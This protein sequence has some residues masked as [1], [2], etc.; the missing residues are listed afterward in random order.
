[1][2]TRKIDKF[3][4]MGSHPLE[5]HFNIDS[6]TTEIVEYKSKIELTDYEDYDNKDKELENDYQ[7][8]MERA[9]DLADILKEKIDSNQEPRFLARLAEVTAQQYN[10]ALNAADKKAK[11][12][13]N[14]DKLTA[15]RPS[16]GTTYNQTIIMDRN[17]ML[18]AILNRIDD[19]VDVEIEDVTP[20]QLGN[21]D[22]E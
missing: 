8:I 17:N 7:I 2:A 13:D 12:K 14:K 4:K 19:A 5:D 1:M 22:N 10:V 11:L 21:D 3:I 18:D 20:K 16:G 6:N 9:L 15:K